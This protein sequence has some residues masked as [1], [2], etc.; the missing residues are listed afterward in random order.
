MVTKSLSTNVVVINGHVLFTDYDWANS[1]LC[2]S[3][4]VH[5]SNVQSIMVTTF[6]LL[7]TL[8]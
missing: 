3:R 1:M 2:V 7:T 8:A 4:L 5:S 6:Q